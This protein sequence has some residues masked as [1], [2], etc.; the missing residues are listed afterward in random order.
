MQNSARWVLPV[1]SVS[2]CRSAR[3]MTHGS[4]LRPVPPATS[5][6]ISAK[7]ISS[8]YSDSGRPSSTRGACLV[9]PMKRPGEQVGQRRVALPVGQQADTSRSGRRSSG[10]S[11]GRDAAEGDVVAAAGAAVRAVDVERLGAPAGPAGPARTASSSCCRCSAQLAVGCTLTSMTPGVGGDDHRRRP[12]V[13]R[14]PVALEHDRAAGLGGGRPRPRRP[15]RR[16]ARAPRWAAGRRRAAR[17]GPRRPCAVGRRRRRRPRRPRRRAPASTR[18]VAA[19][20]RRV[21]AYAGRGGLPARSSPAAAAARPANPRRAARAGRGAVSSR[22]WPSRSSSR[23][24]SGSTHAAGSVTASSSW[25]ISAARASAASASRSSAAA[26]VRPPAGA[27][28]GQP[29]SASSK[30]GRTWLAGSPRPSAMAAERPAARRRA[31]RTAAVRLRSP[32]VG[33]QRR[34]RHSGS[35]SVR[36]MEPDLPARQRLSRIPL[37]L[38]AVHQPPAA[39]TPSSAGRPARRPA[40]ACP[41]R[42]RRWSIAGRPGRRSRRRWARRPWSGATSPAASRSSTRAPSAQ[43]AAPCRLGV[44]QRDPRVL[45]HA[46]HDVGEVQRGLARLGRAR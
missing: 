21:G 6:A 40:R 7:A 31:A 19:P 3:S 37:A 28:R 33:E 4:V 27:P 9:G 12:R 26:T 2:R 29:A 43:M 30:A 8:S 17:R 20:R 38:A 1:M 18:Q 24:C 15:G 41:A 25:A 32:R 23:R 45:V 14:R 42:R 44:G 36:Q 35:P 13:R 10:E 39:P 46:G 34:S 16:N 5:R 11:A 22:R